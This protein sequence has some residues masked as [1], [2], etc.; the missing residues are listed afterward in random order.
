V[1]RE[2]RILSTEVFYSGNH[3]VIFYKGKDFSSVL[4][5]AE[6]NSI[7][8]STYLSRILIDGIRHLTKLSLVFLPFEP[9]YL[10]PSQGGGKSWISGI[11]MLSEFAN[12][13]KLRLEIYFVD[14][15]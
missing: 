10:R 14:T 6:A 8:L 9:T 3:F 2:F 5:Q 11:K 13:N 15:H 4:S 1:N 12:L 7:S